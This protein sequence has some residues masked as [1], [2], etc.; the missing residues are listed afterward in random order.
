MPSRSA[1]AATSFAVW[2]ASDGCSTVEPWIARKAAMSS[3][4]ICD[5]PSSP[6]ETP[7]WEP[8]SADA[9]PRDRRHADEVVGAREEGRERRGVRHPAAHLQ[10]DGG[11]DH[12]LLGDEHLEVAVRVRLAEQLGV[13]RVGDLAVERDDV[14]AHRAERGQRLAVGLARRLLLAE[15]PGGQL[16]AGRP[17]KH[18]RLAGAPGARAAR[19]RSRSPPSSSIAASGVLERL[20]VLAGLVLHRRDALALLRAGDD[21]RRPAR[22]RDRLVV[23]GGDRLDV[24]AVDRD[25]VPAERLGAAPVGVEVPADHRLARLPEPVDVDDRGRGC[26]APRTRRA[27]TPPTSSPRPS[28]SRRTGTTRGRAGGRAACRRARRRPRSAGPG[29]ASRS[30][31]RW[32]GCA[33]SGGPRAAS[34]A[35]GRWRTPRRRRCPRP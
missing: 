32:A 27:R 35:C 2:L 34:R 30:P 10:A 25:R 33:A 7:A 28:R 6:I 31:R 5:G 21:H 18:V 19:C 29:R 15:L 9:R 14:A 23:G 22:R 13:R 8:D 17:S 12:L 3:S 11:G 16:A 20:A 1:S 26:R 4:A 24:V